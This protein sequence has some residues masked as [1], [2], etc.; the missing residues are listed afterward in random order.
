M[1]TKTK[2]INFYQK[3]KQVFLFLG[4]FLFAA[5][6][7]RKMLGVHQDEVP[8]YCSF[9]CRYPLCFHFPC[10]SIIFGWF[11]CMSRFFSYLLA[12]FSLIETG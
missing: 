5:L 8:R 7:H 12:L 11:G 3:V 4:Y 1:L 10:L 2:V 6:M 9:V